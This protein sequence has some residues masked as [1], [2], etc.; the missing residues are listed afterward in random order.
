[1][2]P[3]LEALEARDSTSCFGLG[4][5]AFAAG[6]ATFGVPASF[7]A[8]PFAFPGGRFCSAAFSNALFANAFFSSPFALSPFGF[9]P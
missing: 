6:C 8:L 4:S 3:R 7:A 2:A 1:M 5:S 9:F